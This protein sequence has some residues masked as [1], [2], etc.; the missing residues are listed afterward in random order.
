MVLATEEK[1]IAHG[2]KFADYVT[3]FTL[4]DD[5]IK[6]PKVPSRRRKAAL[7]APAPL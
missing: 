6:P 4:S 7:A 3:V 1:A 5:A 2:A